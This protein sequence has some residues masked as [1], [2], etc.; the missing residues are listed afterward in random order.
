MEEKWPEMRMKHLELVQGVIARMS[1]NG[2]ALKGYCM[3]IVAAFIGLAGA[4]DKPKV[5]FL[6]IPIILVLGV[7]DASY[8]VLERGFR[9]LYNDLRIEPLDSVP[10]FRIG[11][12]H[13]P[14]FVASLFSWSVSL[15]Y[16]AAALILAM[17][18]YL[19]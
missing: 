19:L 14:A 13:K 3:G 15:F 17:A 5:L 10:D 2:A 11:I 1:S 6:G 12:T 18:G 8:L 4:I 16:G 7:L 9:S